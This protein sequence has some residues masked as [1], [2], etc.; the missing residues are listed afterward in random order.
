[1]N[2]TAAIVGVLTMLTLVVKKLLARGSRFKGNADFK[3]LSSGSDAESEVCDVSCDEDEDPTIEQ[4]RTFA[5]LF[6]A[7]CPNSNPKHRL[8]LLVFR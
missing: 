7:E 6:F 1:M 5:D 2:T 3:D 8:I 4:A